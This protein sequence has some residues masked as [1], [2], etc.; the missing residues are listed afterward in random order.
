MPVP[1]ITA[2]STVPM[3]KQQLVAVGTTAL[4]TAST[5]GGPLQMSYAWPGANADQETVFLGRHPDD[6]RNS[7]NFS[8]ACRAEPRPATRDESYDV[9]ITIW[10]FRPDLTAADAAAA[11]ARAFAIAARLRTRSP[12]TSAP[13][14]RR[15]PRSAPST[16]CARSHSCRSKDPA[17]AASSC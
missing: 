13:A 14:S 1:S 6:P 11:E 17:G 12:T 10:T 16:W 3:V 8:Q 9:E 2:T 5:A 7:V 4:A 15:P